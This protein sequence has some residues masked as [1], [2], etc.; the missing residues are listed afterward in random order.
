MES[1]AKQIITQACGPC[2]AAYT[3]LIRGGGGNPVQ[4]D[5]QEKQKISR[6][7]NVKYVFMCAVGPKKNKKI[8][9][10]HQLPGLF[11]NCR[12]Q[13]KSNSP[14]ECGVLGLYSWLALPL[15]QASGL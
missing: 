4:H 5:W 7:E 1:E 6:R 14:D 15:L 2:A 3:V 12:P 10:F 8:D 9:M 13:A 11:V